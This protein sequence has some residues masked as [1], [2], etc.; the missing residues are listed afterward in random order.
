[1]KLKIGILLIILSLGITATLTASD[2][3]SRNKIKR[4]I[5]LKNEKSLDIKIVFGAGTINI[6]PADGDTLLDAL[7]YYVDSN[8]EPEINYYIQGNKGYLEIS[9]S[10]NNS[11]EEEDTNVNINSLDDLNKNIWNIR[12]SQKIIIN[13]QVEM[14]AAKSNFDF[15]KMH[16]T[17]LS[18]K[19]GASDS[20]INF[21]EENPVKMNKLYIEAGVSKIRG[22]NFLNANFRKFIFKGG[23]GMYHFNMGKKINQSADI[24][25]SL[26]GASATVQLNDQT[27]FI[28][29]VNDSFLSSIRVENAEKKGDLYK[30]YNYKNN[31]NYLDIDT[32]IGIGTFELLVGK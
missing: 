3:V 20:R 31:A 8:A 16:L 7:M 18:I 27:P 28:L 11:K 13:M 29:K 26:G 17:G 14:G 10:S 5:L 15:G 6:L 23:I 25:L 19:C 24:K 22:K 9:S 2:S 12:V 21:S 32:E 4:V 30:S 1:M